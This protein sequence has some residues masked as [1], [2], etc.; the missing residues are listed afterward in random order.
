MGEMAELAVDGDE[1][2]RPGEGQQGLELLALGVTARRAP[3]P[4]RSGPPPRP[5]RHSPSM[6]LPTLVSLP[7]MAWEDSTT[8]SPLADRDPL[9]VARGHEGQRRHRL[10]LRAGGDARR[11]GW[12]RGRRC[13]SMSTRRSSGICSSP[14][15]RARATFLPIERPSVATVAPVG[16]GG[17]GD[18]LDPV[19]VAGETGHDHPLVRVG[20]E[21]VAPAPAHRCVSLAVWPSSSALVGVRQQQPDA[22]VRSP[23]HRSGPGRWPARRPG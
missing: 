7:G 4:D 2:L 11:P 3:R 1:G 13:V 18:L 10:A 20:G 5:A 15:E 21:Q 19:D 16:D 17:V 14:I 9:V 22:P 8:R 6:T 23:G 12:G